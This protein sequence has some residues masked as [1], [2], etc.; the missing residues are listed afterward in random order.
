MIAPITVDIKFDCLLATFW[1]A[2]LAML[3]L[4][5]SKLISDDWD[6]ML[7]NKFGP[8][9]L[10]VY[11]ES[12]GQSVLARSLTRILILPAGIIPTYDERNSF[13]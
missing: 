7:D 2:T 5:T 10:I 9:T 11:S 1:M 8:P 13:V 3:V 4:K 12:C 6:R